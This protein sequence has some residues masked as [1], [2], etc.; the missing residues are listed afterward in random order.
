MN[1][2][3]DHAAPFAGIRVIELGM[4]WAAP[5]ACMLLA[6]F[7]AEVIKIESIKKMDWWRG[8][9]LGTPR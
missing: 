6:D 4:G 9:D 7:G 2:K 8:G 3:F 1:N 5:L